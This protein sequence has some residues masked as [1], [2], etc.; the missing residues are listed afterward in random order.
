MLASGNGLI[1]PQIQPIVKKSLH[2]M[3]ELSRH[4]GRVDVMAVSSQ[5][6]VD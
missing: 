3:S 1:E 6:I 5:Y 2:P 4:I